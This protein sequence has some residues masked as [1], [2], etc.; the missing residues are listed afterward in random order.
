VVPGYPHFAELESRCREAIGGIHGVSGLQINVREIDGNVRSTTTGESG[1]QKVCHVVGVSSCKG[2]V[3]KST[4][5]VNL[6]CALAQQ[7]LAV[8]ILDADIYGPSLP[9]LLQSE[10]IVVKRSPNNPKFVL[11]LHA[12]GIPTLK[13]LSFGHV[14]PKAGAPGAGGK[15]AA[16]MRGPLVS[17]VLNQLLL[18]TD[19]GKLDYLIIDMP[20]G[21]GDIQITLTQSVQMSGA[22]VVTTPHRLALVD[23][24]KGVAM[25]DQVNVPVLSIVENMAFFTCRHG[26]KYFPFGQGGKRKLLKEILRQQETTSAVDEANQ[27]GN[28]WSY[29]Q[30]PLSLEGSGLH[31][32]LDDDEVVAHPESE[33][34]ASDDESEGSELK[35]HDLPSVLAAPMSDTAK[36]YKKMANSVI[37][38]L[39]KLQMEAS[40]IPAVLI[41]KDGSGLRLRYFEATDNS[42]FRVPIS[43][44]KAIDPSNGNSREVKSSNKLT[45][46][47]VEMKGQYGVGVTWSDGL[48]DIYR[49]DVLKGIAQD[50]RV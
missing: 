48:V 5:A 37:D 20:P 2:G 16:V 46:D 35:Y 41:E 24:A 4:V 6:A 23:A 28:K 8:G 43:A 11:P 49:Y 31:S 7:G 42:E 33:I 3:G 30:I 18:A 44:L 10:D 19:W 14:N 36:A 50:F 27:N 45:I 13:M 29:H 9:T 22:V 26:E 17:K 39:F 47:R 21:T 34:G 12:K 32:I 15:E 25:F 40:V 38:Q 1:L